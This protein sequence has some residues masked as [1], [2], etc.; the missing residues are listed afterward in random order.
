M[1]LLQITAFAGFLSL[2]VANTFLLFA[3]ALDDE[4]RAEIYG[5]KG[6]GA[7][8]PTGMAAPGAA[9]APHSNTDV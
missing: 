3:V 2:S 1:C 7:N 4:Q 5:P 8:K 9:A 6:R